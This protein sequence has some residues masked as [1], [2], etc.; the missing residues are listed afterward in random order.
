MMTRFAPIL[1]VVAAMALLVGC[2]DLKPIKGKGRTT[3]AATSGAIRGN[4]GGPIGISGTSGPKVKVAM[5]VMSKCPFGVKAVDGFTPVLKK[6]GDRIDFQLDYIA[7]EVPQGQACPRGRPAH[8]GFC[9]LHGPPEVKGNIQQLC[10]RKHYPALA[11]WLPF[12][13]CQNKTWRNIPN[14]W[15]GCAKQ[16]GLDVG[17]LTSCI[18]GD[19]GKQLHSASSKR[20]KAARASGS[21]TIYVAGKQYSGG[22]SLRDFTRAACQGM[23]GQKPADCS[24]IPEPIEVKVVILNDKRCAKCQTAGLESNLRGR[25]FP[26]LT[27]R[28]VDYGSAEGKKL[29]ADLKLTHLPAWL[30]EPGVEKAENYKRIARWMEPMGN[31]KKLKVPAIFDPKAEICDNKVDDTGNG[32]IDCADDTCKGKLECREEKQK[33]LD[34][35]VMSQC[36]FGVKAIDAMKEVLAN[37]GSDLKF[38]VHYI[39]DKVPAGRKC[40]R[41]AEPRFGFC[42]LHGAPEVDENIRQLCAKKYYGAKNKYLDYIW[43]RNKNYRSNEWKS[44]ATNGIS[45]DVIAKCFNSDEGKKLHEA[46]SKLAQQLN[47]SGSPTWLANNR[48]KFS[49]IAADAI[50]QNVCSHNKGMKNCDKNLSKQSKGPAA[51]SCGG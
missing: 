39:A 23:D 33:K 9:A 31:Y 45:A 8:K 28:T 2:Q 24:N 22:R 42:A 20:A 50:K 3:R 35:F 19:E 16:T 11:Q 38:D 26:K 30:F 29:F 12:I 34:V 5:Y 27:V 25:F 1:G 44:C 40:R 7:D 37:F 32:K 21:P 15:E 41:G 13:E 10:V 51:G 48:H 6:M 36:P 47:V 17:K 14:N 18:D 46:S 43:C 49:G 4:T